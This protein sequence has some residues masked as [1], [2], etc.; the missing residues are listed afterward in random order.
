[1]SQKFVFPALLSIFLA[2]GCA[3][4]YAALMSRPDVSQM[5]SF[6]LSELERCDALWNA[7]VSLKITGAALAAAAGLSGG[8]TIVVESGDAKAA[9]SVISVIAGIASAGI[10]AGAL[11]VS[12]QASG[13]VCSEA[14]DEV[15]STLGGT[16]YPPTE[17]PGIGN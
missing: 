5:A 8:T 14:R 12:S 16:T 9:F 7:D 3:S 1:M 4:P 11:A 2:S 10:S 15:I 17:T 6:R 13:P